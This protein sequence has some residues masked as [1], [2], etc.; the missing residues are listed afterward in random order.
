MASGS[1]GGSLD[2]PRYLLP[3]VGFRE[4]AEN[5]I[6]TGPQA[7]PNEVST[8]AERLSR[9]D[10]T[11]LYGYEIHIQRYR[12][13]AEHCV[14]RTVL[15]AGCGTGYG[16][17]FLRRAGSGE[18]VGVDLSSEA[19]AEAEANYGRDGVRFLVGDLEKLDEM[20][21]LP[22]SVDVVVNLENLEHLH[23]PEAFLRAARA[24]LRPSEGIF[25]T[26]TPNGRLTEFDAQG[27][28]VNPYHVKEFTHEE[29]LELLAPHFAQVEVYGQWETNDRKLRLE[30]ERQR[31][32]EICAS[33]YDPFAR[34]GRLLGRAIGRKVSPPRFRAAGAT[35]SWEH[36]IEPIDRK[37]YPWEP[38]VLLAVCR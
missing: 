37:P 5:P 10:R 6:S 1:E 19:I 23:R 33:Y 12:L 25:I 18:I 31:F 16:T 11:L 17:D 32:E 27:R 8:V 30:E 2:G 7:V 35:Y 13:A 38:S 20:R 29:F 9:E 21:D 36:V 24:R 4:L 28:N 26:S 15:D 14:G 22:G 34:L 3:V